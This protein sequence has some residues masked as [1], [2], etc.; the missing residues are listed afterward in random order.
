MTLIYGR[1]VRKVSPGFS[2]FMGL[3]LGFSPLLAPSAARADLAMGAQCD[4]GISQCNDHK[5]NDDDGWVDFYG[6][7]PQ[8]VRPS[9]DSE[10]EENFQA[11]P[12]I[13]RSIIIRVEYPQGFQLPET[14]VCLE[15]NRFE[16]IDFRPLLDAPISQV[17]ESLP[18]EWEASAPLTS[19]PMPDIVDNPN[20][21][22]LRFD[23]RG[24]RPI[25][26]PAVVGEIKLRAP[27]VV[28]PNVQFVGRAFNLQT[29]RSVTNVGT[30][31]LAA[32]PAPAPPTPLPHQIALL[33]GGL[34]TDDSLPLSSGFD[35]SF[36]YRRHRFI[37]LWSWEFETGIAFTEDTVESGLLAQAELHLVR[38][39]NGPPSKVLPFLFAGAGLSHYD[40][41][42]SSETAPLATLGIGAD[43]AWTQR[44]GFRL[45]VRALWLH[46]MISPGWMTNVQVFWG[47]AFSF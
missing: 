41:P 47:P 3:L 2:T 23:Y 5:D 18:D 39:F 11:P 17:F 10:S 8:C 1:Q 22:N 6:E 45:D 37:P 31:S 30:L 38:H 24:N 19:T 13:C 36:L 26:G 21:P 4:L 46:D 28:P 12:L 43:F 25:T 16:L 35:T 15:C 14:E 44:A 9:D 42:G 34:L 33:V 32:A 27:Y 40:S 29:G 7:D 20:I